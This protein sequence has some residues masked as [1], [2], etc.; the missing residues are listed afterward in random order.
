MTPHIVLHIIVVMSICCFLSTWKPNA[1]LI[2]KLGHSHPST[3]LPG[4]LD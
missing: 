1:G 3:T 4:D 2:D